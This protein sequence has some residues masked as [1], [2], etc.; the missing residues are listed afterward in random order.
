MR[1]RCDKSEET[2]T[3][4]ECLSELGDKELEEF[5]RVSPDISSNPPPESDGEDEGVLLT[6]KNQW[7]FESSDSARSSA[8]NLQVRFMRALTQ[9]QTSSEGQSSSTSNIVSPSKIVSP[10]LLSR[11]FCLSFAKIQRIN[12]QLKALPLA[13]V[14]KEKVL[15]LTS[16]ISHLLSHLPLSNGTKEVAYDDIILLM[17]L[18]IGG[19]AYNAGW[20]IK[21]LHNLLRSVE[22]TNLPAY[23][24]AELNQVTKF[25]QK[26]LDYSV[27]GMRNVTVDHGKVPSATHVTTGSG[28]VPMDL[29]DLDLDDLLSSSDEEEDTEV[30]NYFNERD[31]AEVSSSSGR[32]DK[33]GESGNKGGSS[34]Y[35]NNRS[36][37][38]K[39][40]VLRKSEPM[41]PK[42]TKRQTHIMRKGGRFC[43]RNVKGATPVFI[44]EKTAASKTARNEKSSPKTGKESVVSPSKRFIASPPSH[45]SPTPSLREVPI[46]TT[47]CAATNTTAVCSEASPSDKND[48]LLSQGVNL[49]KNNLSDSLKVLNSF[50]S[51]KT[52]PVVSTVTSSPSVPVPIK[53]PVTTTIKSPVTTTIKS[54]TS[55]TFLSTL[56]TPQQVGVRCVTHTSVSSNQVTPLVLPNL[57]N[58]HVSPALPYGGR[59]STALSLPRVLPV[60]TVPTVPRVPRVPFPLAQTLPPQVGNQLNTYINAAQQYLLSQLSSVPVGASPHTS[61]RLPLILQR[62]NPYASAFAQRHHPLAI[63][64]TTPPPCYPAAAVPVISPPVTKRRSSG[65]PTVPVVV[66][67]N[68]IAPKVASPTITALSNQMPPSVASILPIMASSNQVSVT[69]SHSPIVASTNQTPSSVS[70]T[71]TNS[72]VSA[73]NNVASTPPITATSNQMPPSTVT[74]S[75]PPITAPSNQMPPSTVTTSTPTPITATFNQMPPWTITS[76]TLPS[77]TTSNHI[78]S[79]SLDE[80]LPSTVTYTSAATKLS[81]SVSISSDVPY[82]VTTVIAFPKVSGPTPQSSSSSLSPVITGSSSPQLSVNKESTNSV[83]GSTPPSSLAS[84]LISG[85]FPSRIGSV[86]VTMETNNSATPSPSSSSSTVNTGSSS[87][88]VSVTTETTNSVSGSTPPSSS[89]VIT[90]SSS[91]L[92]GPVSVTMETTSSVSVPTPSPSMSSSSMIT[93]AS[94]S[95]PSVTKETTNYSAADSLDKSPSAAVEVARPLENTPTV[96]T[97][98]GQW[99]TVLDT[100]PPLSADDTA[101]PPPLPSLAASV[102]TKNSKNISQEVSKSTSSSQDREACVTTAQSVEMG[103]ASSVAAS[104]PT[105]VAGPLL[106]SNPHAVSI[107]PH[108]AAA[109]SSIFKVQAPP[110]AT[111]PTSQRGNVALMHLDLQRLFAQ[112]LMQRAAAKNSGGVNVLPAMLGNAYQANRGIGS[113]VGPSLS[114]NPG[115]ISTNPAIPI[116]NILQLLEQQKLAAALAEVR[117][118]SSSTPLVPSPASSFTP[119]TSAVDTI[120]TSLLTTAATTTAMVSTCTHVPLFTL[121]HHYVIVNCLHVHVHYTCTCVCVCVCS[122]TVS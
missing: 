114:A 115:Y 35:K 52:P 15:V 50:V 25:T 101:P 75:T 70:T 32:L 97:S 69:S 117:G 85:S 29:D 58:P 37:T 93:G 118:Q 112:S 120:S 66:P 83:S 119:S 6:S 10:T 81:P 39:N 46:T 16:S 91:S 34:K 96:S 44:S 57:I 113:S 84:L 78:S 54:P 48:R 56:G 17:R 22:S 74:M 26:C 49:S 64:M 110:T 102:S 53:S 104:C 7:M 27:T 55:S 76:S 109:W 62:S 51:Q 105:V 8:F 36:H 63:P 33:A 71:S 94:S 80:S 18:S 92:L 45:L 4:S 40:E 95:Q 28:Y 24:K 5:L 90:G 86:S 121:H 3:A 65:V 72:E 41:K 1:S 67:S 19:A 87:S 73:S 43:K 100:Q 11:D 106:G 21:E 38:K 103:V 31:L 61:T 88:S 12:Q 99:Q 47:M 108:L 9:D 79:C 60:A 116:G 42:P 111:P 82:P 68:Q 98:A 14:L 59:V 23:F 13:S 89:S 20:K 77:S 122:L 107:P 2:E 30:A